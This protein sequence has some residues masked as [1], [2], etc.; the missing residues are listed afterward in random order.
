VPREPLRFAAP[1]LA[2]SAVL[3]APGAGRPA[4]DGEVALADG[5][6]E[7]RVQPGEHVL[8]WVET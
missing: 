7:A 1:A 3:H 2:R 4:A 6:A 5:T 8:E